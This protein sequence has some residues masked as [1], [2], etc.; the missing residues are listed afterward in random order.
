VYMRP[1]L[2][3]CTSRSSAASRIRA[4]ARRPSAA[5]PRST[6]NSRSGSDFRASS[7]VAILIVNFRP[8]F[9]GPL[10]AKDTF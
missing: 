4:K 6:K 9:D 5:E 3:R 2:T 1:Q 10:I 7:R 8:I